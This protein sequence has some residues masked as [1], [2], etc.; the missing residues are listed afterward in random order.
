MNREAA[1]VSTTRVVRAGTSGRPPGDR[2]DP[3]LSEAY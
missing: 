1:I 3:E 2:P